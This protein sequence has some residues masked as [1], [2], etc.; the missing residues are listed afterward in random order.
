M[1]FADV[2]FPAPSAAYAATLFFP[3]A[4]ILALATEFGVYAFFRDRRPSRFR[5]FGLVVVVVVVNLF[6][7]FAGFAL[8]F[9]LPSGLVP[10][11]TGEPDHPVFIT[12]T[13]PNWNTLAILSFVWAC[14]LSCGLEYAALRPF[15]RA[16]PIENLAVCVVIANV[17]SYCVIGVVTAVYLYFDLF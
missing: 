11:L 6:S 14:L 3:L 5:L 7:W 15:R 1:L 12:T 9:V 2:I 10:Q 4:G 13:G 16:L 8:S 17:A